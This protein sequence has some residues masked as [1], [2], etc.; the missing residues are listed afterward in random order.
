MQVSSL[1]YAMGREAEHIMKSFVF[2]DD[3]KRKDF[4]FVLKLFDNH[5]IPK[6]NVI[7]ERACFNT[8]SQQNGESVEAFIRNLYELSEH[9]DFGE[10]KSEFIRDRISDKELSQRMQL[11]SGLN[12]E[13]AIQMARNSEMIKSQ[14][15]D[16]GATNLDEVRGARPKSYHSNQSSNHD[17]R[18]SMRANSNDQGNR[19]SPARRQG[20]Y[21]SSSDSSHNCSQC[22]YPSHEDSNKCPARYKRCLRCN[23]PK[24]FQA[25]CRTKVVNEVIDEDETEDM[26]D[27]FFLGS[28]SCDETEAWNVR[29]RLGGK[30]V[31][32]K[33][34]TGADISV[35]YQS[36]YESLPHKPELE[37]ARRILNSPG[38]KLLCIGEFIADTI[39]DGKHYTFRVSVI[40][41]HG[42]N[43]LS[44]GVASQMGL[45]TLNHTQQ[46][47]EI[48]NDVFGDIGLLQCEP[49][50]IVL[51]QDAVP[52]SLSTARRVPFPIIPKVEAELKRMVEADIIE[53]VTK[54]TEWCAPMVPVVK[55]NG[56]I[57]I[58][59]DLKKLNVAVQRE[60]YIL[61][62][63][64]DI[65]PKL[66][67]A[68]FFSKLD[69]S[70][71]FNQIPL[72]PE[73]RL[74][75]TF[76]T[77]IG[78]FFFKRVP[79]GISSAPEIFQR[80]MRD[81]LKGLDGSEAIMD[82][83]LVW[84]KSVEEHDAR[85]NSVLEYIK[86]SGLKLNKEKCEIGKSSLNYFGHRISDKGVEP[87]PEKTQAIRD[88][89]SPTNVTELRRAMGMINYL[90]RYVPDLST[91]IHPMSDLLKDDSIW[92][93]GDTQEQAFKNVKEMLTSAPV[94]QF[95][96]IDKP[97]VVSADASSYGLGA[98]LLQQ[99]GDKLLPVAYGSRTLTSAET[100]Y[101]QI[102]KECLAS[103]WACEKFSRYLYGLESFRLLTDHKPLVPLINKLDLDRAPLRCTRL[104]IR[105][106]RFNARVEHV[107]GKKHGCS[108][109]VVKESS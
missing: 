17:S 66:T 94:L 20:H 95:Y 109:Y 79:F 44:R 74:L 68:K 4:D 22:G 33:I 31:L 11:E 64:D 101:S 73:S 3:D 55:R 106:M 12:L 2:R 98:T 48:H 52:Y 97:T 25:V 6:R 10:K 13:T 32:F 23:K 85:L 62:V 49:V 92:L 51:K 59:V 50:N 82:D 99:H 54:P 84:G 1:V 18:G 28:V 42:S 103:V 14:V 78:R 34:D 65:I 38:G 100:R 67:E 46:V 37:S 15:E 56:K 60:R 83:I 88:L 36:S 47:N 35:M 80:K 91:I 72:S 63:F 41:G 90:G 57:R 93:W 53:E 61:P 7:H 75:T 107:A 70:S 8:R 89:Q 26:D 30:S 104:L 9:C 108:R 40:K 76:I 71:G 5:F 81:V 16:R 102:E 77:P 27:C 24:H 87:D 58:C 39:M 43:L 86:C 45:V 105:L 96:D 19:M 69:A 29:I 21:R